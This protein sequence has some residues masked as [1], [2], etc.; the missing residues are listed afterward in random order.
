MF[1]EKFYSLSNK[2][3]RERFT[4]ANHVFLQRFLQRKLPFLAE[5]CA[6]FCPGNGYEYTMTNCGGTWSETRKMCRNWNG[7]LAYRGVKNNTVAQ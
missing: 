7:D 6:G 3:M 1:I 4:C 2:K 5:R